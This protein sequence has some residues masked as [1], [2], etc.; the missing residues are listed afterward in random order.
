LLESISNGPYSAV[1]HRWTATRGDR[2][3]EMDNIIVFRWD[4]EGRVAERWEFHGD[5]AAHH[6]FW[7]A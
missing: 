2:E 3:I 7:S 1:K 6:R 4:A 5:A